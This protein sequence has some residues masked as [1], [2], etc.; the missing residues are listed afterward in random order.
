MPLLK[1]EL[2]LRLTDSEAAIGSALSPTLEERHEKLKVLI[3]C[4]KMTQHAR[5]TVSRFDTANALAPMLAAGQAIPCL[6]H[7]EMRVNEKLFCT[8]VQQAME[9]HR[10]GD[11]AKRCLPG[12]GVTACVNEKVLGGNGKSSQW[13][14]PLKDDGKQIEARLMTNVQSRKCIEGLK[15]AIDVLHSPE[16]DQTS[17][18]PQQ[19]RLDN[20][21]LSD[22]WHQLLDICAPMLQNLRR[23]EDFTDDD[24]DTTHQQ[25][26]AF[27]STHVDPLEGTNIANYIHVI[28]AG[29]PTH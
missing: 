26:A 14:F 25:M 20:E 11:S 16:L 22:E 3:Q 29:H 28:G 19:T 12:A 8:S 13:K 27:M 21:R 17:L 6:L 2:Q 18:T 10:D 24:I 15:L 4:E 9:R 7:L 23:H 5:S 1:K